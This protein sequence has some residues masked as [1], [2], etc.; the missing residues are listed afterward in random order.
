MK[1][2]AYIIAAIKAHCAEFE[3]RHFTP[4]DVLGSILY[5]KR[6]DWKDDE[7]AQTIE[8]T[9]YEIKKLLC[10]YDRKNED[11]KNKFIPVRIRKKTSEGTLK[12]MHQIK[13]FYWLDDSEF[14]K[15]YYPLYVGYSK[16]WASS[17][18]DTADVK[19]NVAGQLGFI[20]SALLN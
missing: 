4:E 9:V 7:R 1:E 5:L 18:L 10:A 19:M 12:L 6:R 20:D 15:E 2:I 13:G 14:C 16:N 11:M 17:H 3:T 8:L